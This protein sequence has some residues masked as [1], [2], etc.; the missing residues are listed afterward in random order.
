MNASRCFS[1]PKEPKKLLLTW[2]GCAG[3]LAVCLAHGLVVTRGLATPPDLDALR[4]I[5]FAQGILDGNWWGDPAYL[6]ATRY[7]PPLVPGL[8]AGIALLVGS[9]DL[10]RLWIVAGPLLGL[11]PVLLFFL[12]MRALFS[13][14]IGLAATTVFVL[15]NGVLGAPWVSGGYSPWLL[16]P[17]LAQAGFFG[18]SW[19]IHARAGRGRWGDAVLIGAV[20]GTVFLAHVIPA[21]LLSAMLVAAALIGQGVRLRTLVWL[22]I[23]G[24]VQALVMAPYLAPILLAY[25]DGVVHL[26]PGAW[27]ADELRLDNAAL[28]IMAL[29]NLPFLLAALLLWQSRLWPRGLAGAMLAVWIA[30]CVVV[31][32][33]HYGCAGSDAA[34]CRFF[35][36]PVHHFHL[37]LQAAGAGVIGLALARWSPP[38]P[39][40]GAVIAAG[41]VGMWLRQYDAI[42]RDA[43]PAID[44]AAYRWVLANA[45]PDTLFVTAIPTDRD[46]PF[47]PAA[48]AV[49][50]AGRKLV[51]LHTLFSNPYVAWAPR[52]VL[53]AGAMAQPPCGSATWA[54]VPTVH[55]L[56]KRATIM[57][58][59]ADHQIARLDLSG[60]P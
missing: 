29:I 51:E 54:I 39:I 44:L 13:A 5:G 15:W 3:L 57:A 1:E 56:P 48:F 34:A 47:D 41:I 46:S 20:I 43:T 31:L 25:P 50:A 23:T 40:W 52:E 12:M 24:A 59:T 33:R 16:T 22:A 18:T 17:L 37:Y 55:P 11:L 2:V 35:R 45:P 14:R 9:H 30:I 6:G 7:Y 38:R 58:A 10:P 28:T 60:C 49:L 26:T 36:L 32:A 19:L 8:L 4:D 27:V 42:A 21:L 53:R